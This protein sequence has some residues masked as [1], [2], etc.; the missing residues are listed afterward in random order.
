M[1][2]IITSFTLIMLMFVMLLFTG[3]D[4]ESHS[5]YELAM[6]RR[7]FAIQKC[8]GKCLTREEVAILINEFET[9]VQEEYDNKVI[10]GEDG[11]TDTIAP[12][13]LKTPGEHE[14]DENTRYKISPI[15]GRG[16][17]EGIEVSVMSDT[18]ACG[19][20]VDDKKKGDRWVLVDVQSETNDDVIK[21]DSSIS[22]TGEGTEYITQY[23]ND[24][25]STHHAM[26]AFRCTIDEPPAE[27]K[28]GDE[29]TFH[30]RADI[31]SEDEPIINAYM[32][33]NMLVQSTFNPVSDTEAND[34]EEGI[35]AG[36]NTFTGMEFVK[37]ME[38][39][40]HITVPQKNDKNDEVFIEFYTSAGSKTGI[41]SGNDHMNL[42]I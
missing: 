30:L 42:D 37:M 16:W 2:K 6:S 8:C 41:I 14:H 24:F 11:A 7:E 22:F 13:K 1:K 25:D 35:Y 39:T 5:E 10:T 29:L 12:A 23:E 28:P 32:S 26:M 34:T 38:D 4:N 20:V 18:S 21:S 9:N 3:C 17:Y 36:G 19:I 27:L 40:V 15:E 31:I 33:C